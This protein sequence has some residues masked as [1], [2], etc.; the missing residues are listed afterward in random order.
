M[1]AFSI[2]PIE[3]IRIPWRYRS[4]ILTLTKREIAGRYRGS[5]LGLFW[6]L[7]NP[8]FMLAVY[9]FVFSVVFKAKWGGGNGSKTEFALILFAG[10]I[11]FNLFAECFTRAPGLIICHANYVKRVVFPLEILPWVVLGAAI[12]H[13][14]VSIVVWLAAYLL[15]FGIP[16][17]SAFLLPIVYLP[18]CMFM[19]GLSWSLA[20]LGVF[21]RDVSQI[22]GI[23]VTVIMFL[24]P[25]FYPVSAIPE[26]Y[27]PFLY[28]NPLLPAINQAREVLYFGRTPDW[29]L[30][31]GYY[32][33]SA[34]ICWLGFVWFQ[35]TR[36]G[37]A[38]V[39]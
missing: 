20:S 1:Q 12:F 28:L 33:G 38:D 9:T 35:K 14:L 37:F 15:F 23:L 18:L 31:A 27:R 6:S 16:H 19:L 8:L 13:A 5:F 22:V 21:L 10:M 25:I 4:L 34:I 30:L 36:K 39:L 11:V 3:L 32:L 7:F 29:I 17:P 2:S 26:S 24:S